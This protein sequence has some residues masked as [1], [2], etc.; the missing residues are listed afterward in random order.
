MIIFGRARYADIDHLA[1]VKGWTR[2]EARREIAIAAKPKTPAVAAPALSPEDLRE[3]DRIVRKH[4]HTRDE[5]TA[6]VCADRLPKRR[7]RGANA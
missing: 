2:S 7:M 4:G 5:A 3:I 6:I 1:R